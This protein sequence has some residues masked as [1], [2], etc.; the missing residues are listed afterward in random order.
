MGECWVM[1]GTRKGWIC[2][3]PISRP[4][5]T[6]YTGMA[7]AIAVSASA[8]LPFSAVHPLFSQRLVHL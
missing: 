5:I 3:R 7:S 2:G 4:P 8:F 6:L 1:V